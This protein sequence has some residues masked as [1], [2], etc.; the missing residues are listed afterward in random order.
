MRNNMDEKELLKF[1]EKEGYFNLRVL[2]DGI[3]GCIKMLYTYGV[4]IDMDETGHGGRVCYSTEAE[5]R[6]FCDQMK[7]IY[8]APMPGFTADKR[9][10][11]LIR[12]AQPH[13]DSEV[14]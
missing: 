12:D 8:D 7:S 1:L 2:P 14:K 6:N 11:R 9:G 5:A 13:T 3:I 4:C 10:A